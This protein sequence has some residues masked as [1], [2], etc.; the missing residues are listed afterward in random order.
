MQSGSGSARDIGP[1]GNSRCS[2]QF[3]NS[4]RSNDKPKDIRVG[5]IS[6]GLMQR[7]LAH[8]EPGSDFHFHR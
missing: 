6:S 7:V 3:G 1:I 2:P 5:L 8:E 4:Q